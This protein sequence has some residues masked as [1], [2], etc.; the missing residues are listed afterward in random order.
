MP[1]VI[2]MRYNIPIEAQWRELCVNQGGNTGYSRP[3]GFSSRAFL[4]SFV[5][6]GFY[7]N[8]RRTCCKRA[9]STGNR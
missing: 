6:E 1:N 7:G 5:K 4:F 2:L 8:L 3:W 9:C